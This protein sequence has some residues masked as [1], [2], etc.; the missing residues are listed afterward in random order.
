MET[1]NNASLGKF[2][3]KL[4]EEKIKPILGRNAIILALSGPMG[5]G[6]TTITKEIA[7]IFNESLVV[8]SPTFVLHVPYQNFDHLDLWRV[9]TWDE[10]ERLGLLQM[11]AQKR[12]IVVEWAD[13]FK[14]QILAFKGQEVK[15]VWVEIEYGGK[16]DERLVKLGDENT[17]S[18]DLL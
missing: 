12:L 5:A 16:E 1:V 6:K 17:S 15:I 11:I 13:K 8:T 4:F 14:D 3:Q 18:G 7:K 10:V 2:A 9:E